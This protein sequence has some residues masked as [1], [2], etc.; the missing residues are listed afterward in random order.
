M[1][2]QNKPS[3][4]APA[5]T[6]QSVANPEVALAVREL[7]QSTGLSQHRFAKLVGKPQSTIIRI[8]AGSM[9]ASVRVLR[10]IAT[11]AG[12]ELSIRFVTPASETDNPDK[13]LQ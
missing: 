9:N 13:R 2:R 3:A 10:D 8:E 6:P 7:R 1:T 4:P 5:P 12:K 11:A